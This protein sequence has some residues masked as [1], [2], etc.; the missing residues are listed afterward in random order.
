M[1]VQ[2]YFIQLAS[3]NSFPS[4]YKT[5]AVGRLKDAKTIYTV[6]RIYGIYDTQERIGRFTSLMD[7]RNAVKKHAYSKM[8]NTTGI[9][10]AL[11]IQGR[12]LKI[13]KG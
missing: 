3:N 4:V 8:K 13:V 11:S 2:K 6:S 12:P 9:E 10:V 7:A 5:I 1:A